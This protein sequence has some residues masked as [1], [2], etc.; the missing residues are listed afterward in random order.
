M[1]KYKLLETNCITLWH[2]GQ[3]F[4]PK[5]LCSCAT[6]PQPQS[7]T[8][9]GRQA[10][11]SSAAYRVFLPTN[12]AV[13]CCNGKAQTSQIPQK[14]EFLHQVGNQAKNKCFKK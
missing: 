10:P 12:H 4:L 8:Q 9:A 11:S 1:V 6:S 7:A 13:Y 2:K 3:G 5:Q 14:V